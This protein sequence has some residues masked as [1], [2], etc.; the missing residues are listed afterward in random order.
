MPAQVNEALQLNLDL[1]SKNEAFKNDPECD[2]SVDGA[3]V[4]P[5]VGSEVDGARV[6]SGD[7]SEVV[8]AG[9]GP[10]VGSDVVGATA[11]T[12]VPTARALATPSSGGLGQPST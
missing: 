10:G 1:Q 9:V 4:G 11:P 8:G 12:A 7:G 6:G 2:P 5:G 3:V